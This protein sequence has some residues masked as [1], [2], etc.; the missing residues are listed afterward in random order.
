MPRE[1]AKIL[2]KPRILRSCLR[3]MMDVSRETLAPECAVEWKEK[4]GNGT[5]VSWI[6]TTKHAVRDTVVES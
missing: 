5:N 3:M 2:Y 4:H 6:H 1:E